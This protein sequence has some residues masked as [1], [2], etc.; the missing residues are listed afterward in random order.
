[1]YVYTS[2]VANVLFRGVICKE[3]MD[4]QFCIIFTKVA[5]PRQLV[6]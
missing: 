6:K 3:R 4:L 5:T 1:M 2:Y